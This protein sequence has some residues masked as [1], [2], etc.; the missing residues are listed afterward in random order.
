M[1]VC[2]S[3]RIAIIPLIVGTLVLC[4]AT[5]ML[6]NP[7]TNEHPTDVE[8][9]TPLWASSALQPLGLTVSLDS[10]AD[11]LRADPEDSIT[12]PVVIDLTT[13]GFAPGD[14]LRLSYSGWFYF[15][16]ACTGSPTPLDDV[17]VLSVFSASATLLASDEAHRIPDAIDTGPDWFT[18]PT[19]VHN[20]PRDIPEDFRIL[21]GSPNE[22]HPDGFEIEVPTGARYLFVAVGDG[23]YQDNCGQLEITIADIPIGYGD[24][25]GRVWYDRNGDGFQ[26]GFEPGLAGVGVILRQGGVRIGTA[27]TGDGGWYR[28]S[29][30]PH[31]TYIVRE[32][33]PR[34]LRFSSTPDEMIVHVEAGQ[35]TRTDFGDWNGLPIYF[36]W[37]SR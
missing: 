2:L 16:G 14:L 33:Q 24:I 29:L 23:W 35:E 20:L 25:A 28:F 6:A 13:A 8:P 15:G 30:L 12:D 4:G 27:I 10:H 31:G 7:S 34:D 18:G 3:I 36:P 11:F 9:V 5:P 22:Q 32:D 19:F 37:I 21:P 17:I 26:G 1:N